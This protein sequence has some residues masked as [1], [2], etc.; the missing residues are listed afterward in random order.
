MYVSTRTRV[1]GYVNPAALACLAVA[2]LLLCGAPASAGH[3]G[4]TAAS[5]PVPGIIRPAS[6]TV[7]HTGSEACTGSV[8]QCVV[9]SFAVDTSSY[10]LVYVYTFG[11]SAV[12]L[13][14]RSVSFTQVAY[15]SS[16]SPQQY[17]YLSSSS[18]SSGSGSL[19]ANGTGGAEHMW[20]TA[21]DLDG[22]TYVDAIAPFP[23]D[24]W[25]ISYPNPDLMASVS[26]N[27]TGD[28]VFAGFGGYATSTYT[29]AASG[30]STKAL[31][32]G[33]FQLGGVNYWDGSVFELTG[34]TIGVNTVTA[35]AS[36]GL[37]QWT[38]LAIAFATGASSASLSPDLPVIQVGD[39]AVLSY[40]VSGP[41]TATWTLEVNG[42]VSNLSGASGGS[43]TF[44]PIGPGTYTFYLNATFGD[45]S[46]AA[47]TATVTVYAEMT[48]VIT[49][50]PVTIFSGRESYLNYTFT[51]G[52][53]PI[54][55]TLN[56]NGSAVNLSGGSPTQYVFDPGAAGNYTFYLNAT[57]AIYDTA[58]ASVVV[59][60]VG[61]P[62]G[63]PPQFAGGLVALVATAALCLMLVTWL[64]RGKKP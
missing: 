6:V 47:V 14:Y 51:G 13:G 24:V 11:V 34:G 28:T 22:A 26:A 39:E 55:W 42:S 36:T 31:D 2:V 1:P 58:F 27:G 32:I 12:L 63:P 64:T 3:A 29:M 41:P 21:V 59:H 30:S 44:A 48:A 20:V 46:T 37:S 4:A 45:A 15:T 50:G 40:T 19:Y 5:K 43:Y 57:D 56:V 16:G 33:T 53:P 62:P 49:A 7:A 9:S 10:I 38:G 52:V 8:T 18:V 25:P 61:A 17:E 54:T 35:T 60:V 23:G